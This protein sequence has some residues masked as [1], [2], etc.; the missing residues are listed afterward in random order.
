[1]DVSIE[2]AIF[3]QEIWA[4]GRS[5]FIRYA[6]EQTSHTHHIPSLFLSAI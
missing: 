6:L 4:S 5:L 1:M 3:L 2:G